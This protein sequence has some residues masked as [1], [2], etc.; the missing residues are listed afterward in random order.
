[1]KPKYSLKSCLFAA[2]LLTATGAAFGQEV[3]TWQSATGSLFDAARWDLNRV[4]SSTDIVLINNAG[5]ATIATDAGIQSVSAIRLGDVQDGTE[6]G[7]IVMNGG[8]LNV[9]NTAGDPKCIIGLSA[10]L[11]TFIMNGGTIFFDGPDQF[12]GSSADDGLNGLDWEVGEK[13]LGRFEMHGTAKFFAGDDLK[14]GANGAGKGSVLIDGNAHF[15]AGSGISVSEGGPSDEQLMIVGGNALV[16]A[17]NSM[18]AG[19]AL[20]STDEGYLTMASGNSSGRLV[21]QDNGVINYRRLSAREGTSVIVVKDRAQMHIFD[22][23]TG[24]G[25]LGDAPSV[26]RPPEMGPNSTLCSAAP[27]EGTLTLQ[28]D[29]VMTVNSDPASGPTKG[30]GISAPR[31]FGNTGG[32]AALIVRDRASFRV[33]QNL[34]VGTGAAD[35]SDGTL[36]VIGPSAKVNIGGNLNLAVDLE[37][38]PTAGKGTLNPVITAAS[39]SVVNVAGVAKLANGHLKV[40]L[41]GYT[42]LGGESY[43]LVK[44]GTIEGQFLMTD[45][46]DAPLGA[47]MAWV[48]EYTADAVR[49]KVTGGVPPQAKPGLPEANGLTPLGNTVY[50]NP[51]ATTQNNGKVESLG[52]GVIANGNV[53]VGWEDDGDGLTDQEAVWTVY[54][55]NGTPLTPVTTLT[56]ID[57]DYVGQTISSRF[58]AY[59][60]AD[61]SAV[62]GRTAW[63]PKI[64]A[65]VF[66]EGFGMGATAFDL[67][68]EVTALT[69]T[70]NNAA[71]ENAGDF[72]AVQLLNNT[73]GPLG[74]VSGLSEAYA[75]RDGDVRIGDW[76]YLA[77][78][79]I[80]I[81]GESR[82][83]PDLVDLYAGAEAKTHGIVRVVKADGT[84]VKAEQ[85]LGKDPV[86]TQIWHG[87][88]VTAN[89]FAVRYSVTPGGAKLQRF[90]NAGNKVGDEIDLAT[91]TGSPIANGGGRG[92]DIG[93]HGNGKDAYVL[94]TKGLDS[95][96]KPQI[97]LAVLN[98]DGT[99]RWARNVGDGQSL[100]HVAIGRVD[101]A[102]DESG[103]VAVIYAD[104]AG[105]AQA[106]GTTALILGRLFDAQGN[107]LG[108]VFH[109]SEKELPVAESLSATDARVDWRGNTLA[110]AWE[111]LNQT[112]NN[113][114]PAKSVVA[115]RTF[116]VPGGVV[117]VP[118]LS[119]ARNADGSLTLTYSGTLVSSDTPN[120]TYTPVTDAKANVP[121]TLTPAAAAGAKFYRSQN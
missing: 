85:L 38:T 103:R 73:G 15:A 40:K 47:G 104:T 64:K 96:G 36:T 114:D 11:S 58:L 29:A 106:G 49:L 99:K 120:G 1:M 9:G 46:A 118:T 108:G 119:V 28:D 59:F 10:T 52:V 76:D 116:N 2:G 32:K 48:V 6:S 102:I 25:A 44:A 75:E 95:E 34:E 18:G 27:S 51:P 111:S 5:T 23:L 100:P 89:G 3:I 83:R 19:N 82:Q 79:N 78:G 92:E 62:S 61:G 105:T 74:I 87:S 17:G 13:G 21:V 60:R 16:E 93:L 84:V 70:Q 109:V 43:T 107:P 39:H 90:D 71:G 12:P 30:L 121:F 101:A 65:N 68:K 97:W 7:H 50:V 69:P 14:I 110:V 81:V 22:V 54:S 33:E 24:K 35:S 98:A 86:E 56:S 72:P 88:A 55:P 113:T 117:T 53:V 67:G 91:L 42:P 66:G 26:D 115:L 94:A 63:G 57:P 37:G 77:N 45:F 112:E 20:G 41:D 80:V 8:T 31:D 4:P